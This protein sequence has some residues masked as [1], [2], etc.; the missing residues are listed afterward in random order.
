MSGGGFPNW[1]NFEDKVQF[2]NDTS[3]QAGRHALKFGVDYARLPKHGGI[4]GPGSPGGITFWDDPSV[5]LANS[6][7]RYPQGFQTPGAVRQITI[8]TE[9][10]GNYDSYNNWTFAGYVQDD[11]RLSSRLTV[12]LGLRYDIYEHMNQGKD[13]F[14]KNRTYQ[15]LN[16]IGSP[17]GQ[18]PKTD[19]NNWGPR[20]GM[21]WDIS[22]DG[23]R[24]LRASAGRYFTLGIK[25]S[26]Y[27]AAVQD[28]DTVFLSQTTASP[29][30]GTGAL[31]NFIYGVTPL[32]A[33]QK[34]VVS[35]PAG[36]D[37]VGA[38][39]DPNL[40]D[41]QTD[42]Y[43]VGYS[44]VLARD[45]VLSLDYSHYRGNKGW[46][47][48]NI[49]PLLPDPNNPAG[50]RVRP[51]AAD[52]QRVYGDPRLLGITTSS[53][54]ST[55]ASTMRR[56]PTSRSGS[57]RRPPCARAT[58]WHLREEWVARPTAAPAGRHRFRRPPR[59]RAA[60]STHRGSGA[61]RRSTNGI[62]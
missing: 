44:H 20:V 23:E 25:N 55:T 28:K 61:T 58:C 62:V 50:A 59:P 60:I 39:Y 5:I 1:Y 36:R 21:A 31:A 30:F 6:N 27:L 15:V 4:Y 37:N 3:I 48:L 57:R 10:I 2:R 54:L 16:A 40:Q 47:T 8:T 26:Y 24:V 17:Y 42:Q 38:W 56:L 52:L 12:N 32:P 14:A 51:L 9:P 46:R 53:P 34:D 7:G 18:L 19:K 41:F 11:L 49:N 13:L 43:A 22:G 35:L 45:T 33:V 29:S